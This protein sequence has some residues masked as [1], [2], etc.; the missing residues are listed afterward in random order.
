[1]TQVSIIVATYN[2]DPNKL[3]KTLEAAVSQRGVEVEIVITDDGSQEKDFSFVPAFF[4]SHNFTQYKVIENPI[5][6]GTVWNCYT[7]VC[8]ASGEYVFTTSPGDILFDETTMLRFYEFAK[9]RHS[10]L[11]FGNAVRYKLA[12][13]QVVCTN[14]HSIPATPDSYGEGT[15]LKQQKISFFGD[16]LIIGACYFRSHTFAKTYLEQ[17][18]DVVKYMEDTPS[19][20][21]ALLDGIRIDYFDCNII[22]YEDEVGISTGKNDKW[23]TLLNQDLRNGLSELRKKHQGNPYLE[24]AWKNATEPSRWKR[25]AYRF[26][27]HP[28]LSIS[29]VIEKRLRKPREICCSD[30]DWKRLSRLVLENAED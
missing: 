6:K 5:N 23:R 25:I 17:L 1:M 26:M 2:A 13:N 8:A 20:M 14:T 7:G 3:R 18:L 28:I 27:M 19:T 11:C 29:M 15:S 12:N 21:S 22:F 4:A 9:Q 30:D 16:N 24:I 10:Q